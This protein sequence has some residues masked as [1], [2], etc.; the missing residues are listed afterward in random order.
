MVSRA[1]PAPDRSNVGPADPIDAPE[2]SPAAREVPARASAKKSPSARPAANARLPQK[3]QAQSDSAPS[4]SARSEAGPADEAPEGKRHEVLGLVALAL[5]VFSAL[6]LA[7]YDNRGGRDWAGP[8]GTVLAE[9]LIAVLGTA[10]VIVP[11]ALLVQSIH[12]FR[13]TTQPVRPLRVLGTAA[14]VLTIATAL[15]L[16]MGERPLLGHLAAGGLVGISTGETLRALIGTAGAHLVVLTALLVALVVRTRLSVVAFARATGRAGAKTGHLAKEGVV[17]V[18]RAWQKARHE[19][20]PHADIAESARL[21]SPE[22]RVESALSSVLETQR[23]A[24][25]EDLD[26]PEPAVAAEQSPTPASAKALFA[27]DSAPERPSIVALDEPLDDAPLSGAAVLPLEPAP[28][29]A[30]KK[31]APRRRESAADSLDAAPASAP[32]V[33]AAVAPVAP[34]LASLPP[35]VVHNSSSIAAPMPLVEDEPELA[36]EPASAPEP[37]VAAPTTVVARAQAEAAQLLDL[38]TAPTNEAVSHDPGPARRRVRRAPRAVVVE[39]APLPPVAVPPVAAPP[40]PAP[41]VAPKPVANFAPKRAPLPMPAARAAVENVAD[42]QPTPPTTQPK[43][44]PPPPLPARTSDDRTVNSQD[45]RESLEPLPIVSHDEEIAAALETPPEHVAAAP[46]AP[47]P[48]HYDFPPSSLLTPAPKDGG[49]IDEAALRS[50]ADRL[51]KTLRDYQIEGEI[52]EIHPGPVV[53]TFEFVPTAGTKLARIAARSDDIAMSLAVNKVRIVAPI[54][55]KGRVGFEIPNPS[56]KTVFFREL[57]DTEAFG[58]LGGALPVALGKDVVGAPFFSDLAKMPHL[59]VAGA[60]GQGKS[61]GLNVMLCSMLYKR[62]PEEVRMLMIDPKM[63]ELAVYDGIPH[64]LLPVVTDMKK[65]AIALR[66]V[67][68]EMERRYSLFAQ[69]GS[70]NIISYNERVT[71]ALHDGVPMKGHNG[72]VR[73]KHNGTTTDVSKNPDAAPDAAAANPTTLPYIVVVVDE[74]ADLMMVAG[75]EVEAAVARLAQKARAAGIHVILATQRPSVDVITGMIKANFPSR[76]GFK[77]TSKVDSRTILDQQGAENLLGMGD[78]LILPPGSSD[79]RRV[80]CAFVSEDEVQAITDHWRKQG[81]PTYDEE[82]LRPR[83]EDEENAGEEPEI[84]VPMEKYEKAIAL[85]LASRRCS[86]SWIQR[87]LAIGYNV[88]ARIVERMEREG[89]VSAPKG[90]GK[91]REVLG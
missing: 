78:M 16:A 27:V 65:A 70:R 7:S 89:I 43:S 34:A 9:G 67:V 22:A 18:A 58:K 13:R 45:D 88:A 47:I 24:F 90:P 8:A 86:V 83:D 72:P 73:T 80:H 52:A 11:L 6:A 31:R 85:V 66:W 26:A 64:M 57:V 23:D 71:K 44:V 55:G 49:T 50:Q 61:V 25:D 35:I 29:P 69:T 15:H 12:F 39:G 76:V 19:D 82:I 37:A 56:R 79:L 54:P 51:V 2:A 63:V 84:K 75:K 41:P 14:I 59:I 20:D 40:A 77:V 3:N 60:T 81:T 36:D 17:T 42:V 62:G 53:T 48:I 87:Q 4:R 5:A 28:V 74:F 10:S 68:D 33:A 30:V 21:V 91:D 32:A 38:P 46:K 1:R